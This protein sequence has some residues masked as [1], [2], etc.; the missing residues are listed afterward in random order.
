MLNLTQASYEEQYLNY[1]QSVEKRKQKPLHTI[2]KV[3]DLNTGD[4][5]RSHSVNLNVAEKREWFFKLITWAAL[6]HHSVETYHIRDREL[7]EKE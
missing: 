3:Y 4:E 2:V 1:Q 6:N 5:V 7:A